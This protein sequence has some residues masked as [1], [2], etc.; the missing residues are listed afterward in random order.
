LLYGDG[1]GDDDDDRSVLTLHTSSDSAD[2]CLSSPL[3]SK[4]HT[5]MYVSTC[6]S[7]LSRISLT[8]SIPLLLRHY[9]DLLTECVESTTERLPPDS[10]L[11]SE[12]VL[13][14]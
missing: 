8:W 4:Q 11:I 5:F 2:K 10:S 7:K 6:P 9:S 12:P 3:R 1:S 13:I 14:S